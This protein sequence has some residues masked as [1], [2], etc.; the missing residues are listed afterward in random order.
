MLVYIILIMVVLISLL[1]ILFIFY[2]D[3]RLYNNIEAGFSAMGIRSFFSTQ[4]IILLLVFIIFD[5]EILFISSLLYEI[6][7][8]ISMFFLIYIIITVFLE[9]RLNTLK[10]LE[11]TR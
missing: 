8:Y 3:N 5:L 7:P 9:W 11:F 2:K 1:P 10:W 4:F 6:S